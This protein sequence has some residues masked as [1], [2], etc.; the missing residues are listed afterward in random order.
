MRAKRSSVGLAPSRFLVAA[1]TAALAAA[2]AGCG[3]APASTG[4]QKPTGT[5]NIGLLAEFSGARASLGPAKLQGIQLAI[6]DIDAAGGCD[7]HK[8]NVSEI[9]GPDPVDTV[10]SLRKALAGQNLTLVIGPDVN[11]YQTALPIMEGA[12]MVNF[13]YIGTPGVY[14]SQHWTYSFRSGP[15]DAFVGAAMMHYAAMKGYKKVAIVLSADQGSQDLVP[16]MK[17]MA[18]HDGVQIVANEDVPINVTSY[19]GYVTSVVNAHP[20][21]VLFQMTTAGYAGQW[22]AEWQHEGGTAIPLIGSDFTA[23]GQYVQAMGA[24]FAEAHMVSAVPALAVNDAAGQA[25]LK[26]FQNKFGTTPP[27]YAPHFYDSL[28]VACLAMDAAN[29]TNPVTYVKYITKVTTPGSG[30]TTVYSYADGYKLL[31]QGKQIKYYGVGG[32]MTF[33]PD[34]AVTA[35]YQVV[36]TDA[37]GNTTVLANIAAQE[38]APAAKT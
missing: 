34:H 15:S 35:P 4:S 36:R 30:H 32:S 25:F 12:K 38:L 10:T 6:Q 7:G 18:K 37:Q 17:K 3:S 21:A 29:S 5:I 20:D 23:T 11:S 14:S 16:S 27:V 31:R 13:T 24:S 1:C 26:A 9:D 19:A 22:S 28:V 8:V 2:V 33:A